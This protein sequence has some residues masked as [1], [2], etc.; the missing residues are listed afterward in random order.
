M[1][2]CSI[3]LSAGSLKSIRAALLGL[4]VVASVACQR[5]APDPAPRAEPESG[6]EPRGDGRY[7][8]S[9][10]FTADLAA[11]RA[12]MATRPRVERP[13]EVTGLE[14]I[15]GIASMSVETC[16]ACHAEIAAEWRLSVH[17]QAWQDPQ[18]QAEI[19]KSDNRWLC[20]NCHTPLLTQ[21]DRLPVAIVDDDV[22][23]PR[24][25]ENARF[26][27]ALR[28]EGLNCAGCHVREDG[29][30]GPGVA[31]REPPHP[32]VADPRFRADARDPMC[33]D[34]HQAEYVYADKPF[35]CTFQTGE[36]WREGPYDDEGRACGSCHMP[37]VRRPAAIGG[38][39]RTVGRH[40]FKGSGIPKFADRPWPDDVR[41]GPGLAV[42]T[43]LTDRG[44]TVTAT[45]ANA[46]HWLPSGDPER[47]VQVVTT[48]RAESGRELDRHEQ[49]FGQ[50]WQWSV[51]PTK[52]ADNRLKPRESRSWTLPVP[53]TATTAEVVASSHRISKENAE[54]H[55][56][57]DYPRSVETHRIQVSVGSTN[58]TD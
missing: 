27:A 37:R 1:R 26:D 15:D 49:R 58:A 34:C 46:G 40:W 16:E 43:A 20:V 8:P 21:Q 9:Q 4:L 3:A 11:T 23:Q 52:I 44:L 55:G 33:L 54:Y 14:S 13:V 5:S 35:V 25:V 36:E 48:F 10:G 42:Q 17:A 7:V 12:F 53:P 22:E 38:P 32:V 29:I 31:A 24:W 2:R 39:I 28:E 45:N 57:G 56:L 30:H 19:A 51:P 18:F 6:H 50:T 41:P 47:W